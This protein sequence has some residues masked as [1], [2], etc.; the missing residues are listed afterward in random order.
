MKRITILGFALAALIALAALSVSSASGAKEKTVLTLST[1]K[2][3]P[4][5]TG[6]KVKDFSNNLITETKDGNLECE[7]STIEWELT[8][9]AATKDTGTGAKDTEFGDYE[10]IPGA[11][12]T[13]KY[14]PAYITAV[15][16]GPIS[17]SDKGS[18]E[19][20]GSKKIS[21]TAEFVDLGGA[22]CTLE[23]TKAK[24]TMNTSGPVKLTITKQKFKAP[25]GSNA[26]CPK[27]GTLSGEFNMTSE[28]EVVEAKV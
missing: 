23:G 22:K 8:K 21:Y 28:G 17:L 9:N 11:C 14:G 26:A 1:A 7:E 3:G 18:G 25:K 19:L 13:G 10:G 15:G 20:K 2:G 12:K 24:F 4:L 6:A 5:K 27:E 16:L